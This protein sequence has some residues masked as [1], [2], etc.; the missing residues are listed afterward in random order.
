MLA[1]LRAAL[2]ALRRAPAFAAAAAL[3]A[4]LGVG[5]NTAIF[6]AV[7]GVLL[8]A[9]PYPDPA[10]LV[11]VWERRAG[12]TGNPRNPASPADFLDW[13]AGTRVFSDLGALVD[14]RAPLTDVPDPEEVAVE[15][16]SAG[17]FTTVGA[18]PALG[19][20]IGETDDRVG[21][22][23]V[24]VIRDALWRRRFGARPHALGAL[25]TLGGTRTR[26]VGVMPPGF[27]TLNPD[28]DVWAPLGLDPATDYRSKAGRSLTVVVPLAEQ[29]AGDVRRP[30]GVLTGVAALVLLIA[31]ANV[32]NLQLV[33]GTSRAGAGQIAGGS[34]ATARFRG[35]LVAG[36]IA[37]SM[38][39][40]VSA[41]LFARSLVNITR[42]QLGVN[43]ERV[44]TFALA[45]ER[46]GCTRPRSLAL[47]ERAEQALAAI[48]GVSG[49]ASARMGLLRGRE[50]QLNVSVEGFRPAPD[51][52]TDVYAEW[53]GPAFFRVLG[54]SLLAGRE[55][56]DADRAG[57]PKVAVVNEAFARKFGLGRTAVGRHM[58]IGQVN[59]VQLDREIVGVVRDA[60][61][62]HVKGDVPPLFFMPA[63]QDTSVGSMVFYVRTALDAET[64]REAVPAVVR[65]L[66]ANLPV[67]DLKTLPAQVREDTA[68]DRLV[69]TLAGAFAALATG[70]AA[71][72]LY[73]VLSYT[74]AQ[75]TRE[76]GVR[77]ALGATAAAVRRELS[78]VGVETS[79]RR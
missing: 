38:A 17:V 21:A 8:R 15:L 18:R 73:G 44:V 55:F 52:N 57:A 27:R 25:L 4:A 61:Y 78:S 75:R 67:E 51:A 39:L 40:L 1:D 45:P 22:E 46:N 24:V 7:S 56:T 77:M 76:L 68:Q 34:R 50:A 10:R 64:L 58:G 33:R 66:D 29:I 54:T 36:Q 16:A 6:S 20:T 70:L 59:G 62:S 19:R 9:L 69:G 42:E 11:V 37:L 65:R 43:V 12:V 41:G 26:V 2:R 74:V 53:A 49:V 32:A 35:S 48:P 60:K 72:G 47:F 31:C 63:R 71:V 30:L 28:V 14:A 3:C 23:P 13:R 5:A 79:G